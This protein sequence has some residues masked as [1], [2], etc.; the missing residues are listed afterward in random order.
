MKVAFFCG[1]LNERGT[2]VANYDYAHF[3]E[4][5][6]H[7]ESIIITRKGQAPATLERF[8]T[9]FRVFTYED[10]DEV[11]HFITRESIDVC[12]MLVHGHLD[13]SPGRLPRAC[14]LIVHC[15]FNTRTPFGDV[16][17]CISNYLNKRCGTSYPVVPHMIHLPE[18]NGDLRERLGIPKEAIVFGRHGGSDTFNI[19]FV[20]RVIEKV[21]RKRKD[22][23]FLFLNTLPF[24]AAHKQIIHLP[25]IHDME[26]KT[27]FINT[28]D[29]TLHARKGG[30]TFGI[31]VGEFSIKNKPV[32][33]WKPP[34]GLAYGGY[35][36]ANIIKPLIPGAQRLPKATATTHFEI[37]QD[38]ALPYSNARELYSLL[39][40]FDP[41]A[42]QNKNWDA[43]SKDYSPA[44][45]M[46]LFKKHF[47]D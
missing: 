4:T 19:Q 17:A 28:C 12:Y 44:P 39:T 35:Y 45:V 13:K 38:K 24:N 20:H 34:E 3:N 29:A 36:L 25:A 27:A 11:D 26:Q 33:T 37:L 6:L 30:E 42:V 7:N 8:K 47:L 41:V 32:I 23:Y 9:R 22:I 16:Y 21:I 40:Q 18:F 46:A 10:M 14:K 15:V 31:A 1:T 5:L 43:Y 2:S